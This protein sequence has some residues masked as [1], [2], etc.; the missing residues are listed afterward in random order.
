MGEKQGVKW[1]YKL[2][3]KIGGRVW[4][5]YLEENLGGKV[6]ETPKM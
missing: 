3:Q 4:G 5:E 2:G 1:L 6:G